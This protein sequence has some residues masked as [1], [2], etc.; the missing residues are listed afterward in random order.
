MGDLVT[1]DDLPNWVPG[2]VTVDSVRLA[3]QG[4]RVRG[5]RYAPLD[6]PIPEIRRASCRERV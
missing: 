2:E 5:Y 3:W 4:L 6:V 1:P